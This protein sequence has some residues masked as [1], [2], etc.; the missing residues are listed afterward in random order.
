MN[1]TSPGCQSDP[2]DGGAMTAYVC[3]RKNRKASSLWLIAVLSTAWWCCGALAASVAWQPERPVEIVAPSAPGGGTDLTART[4]QRILQEKRLVDRPVSI[5]NKPGGGGDVALAYL[6]QRPADGHTLE[7]A[8]ALLISN[9]ITGKSTFNHTDFLPL[10]QLNSEYV[11]FAVRADSPI[12]TGRDLIQTLGRDPASVSIA[13]GT[14]LAGANHV[15]AALATRAAG[16]DM[17]K[18]KLVVFKSSA[19]SATALLGGHVDVV[20]S[21]ASLVAPH[22]KAGTLRLI[23]I[24]APRRSDVLFPTVPTWKEQGYDIVIDNFRA[25]LGPRGMSAAQ[26]AYWDDALAKLAQTDDWKKDLE[27]NYWENNYMGSQE[28]RK[29]FDEQ[30]EEWRRVLSDLGLAVQR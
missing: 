10:A 18:L 27:R 26:V 1:V 4:L 9:H 2:F 8:T 6:K 21:S 22:F 14:S 28:S 30:Y 12:K 29:Y 5:L 16:S 3:G 11:A 20:A 19:E 13:V 17:K 23:A 25:L 24:T 7:V 15:A